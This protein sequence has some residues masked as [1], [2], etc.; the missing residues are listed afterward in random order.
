MHT[1]PKGLKHNNNGAFY[2]TKKVLGKNNA[3]KFNLK[4]I[5][6]DRQPKTICYLII[7]IFL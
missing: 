2:E 5:S 6:L 7:S 3:I 4:K 1:C